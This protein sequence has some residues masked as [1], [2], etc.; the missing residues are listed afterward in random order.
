M[1]GRF[2][3]FVRSFETGNFR[4]SE[5][6]ADLSPVCEVVEAKHVAVTALRLCIPVL[7]ETAIVMKHPPTMLIL[8]QRGMTAAK[9]CSKVII[10]V[11][12]T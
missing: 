11:I 1:E 2:R 8:P 12:T 9:R 7:N 4:S 5:Q 6:A 10:H 3:T